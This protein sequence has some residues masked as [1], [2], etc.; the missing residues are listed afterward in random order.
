MQ[1]GIKTGI[2]LAAVVV[3]LP[4]VAGQSLAGFQ[5]GET[6]RVQFTGSNATLNVSLESNVSSVQVYEQTLG[7]GGLNLSVYNSSSNRTKMELHSFDPSAGGGQVAV[8][9]TANTTDGHNVT[10]GFAGLQ[11]DTEYQVKRDNAD[12][13]S[14]TTDSA[15]RKNVSNSAWS[16][17]D[18]V[19][20]NTDTSSDDSDDDTSDDDGDSG[21]SSSGA[22][23]AAAPN[24]RASQ[25]WLASQKSFSLNIER[26]DVEVS[27]VELELENNVSGLSLSVEQ[28][29]GQ[30]NGTAELPN[31]YTF[32]DISTDE[33]SDDNISRV[34]VEV[35]VNRSFAEQFDRVQINRYTG[36]AWEPLPTEP[37][38][39]EGE[40]W[41][42][43]GVSEGN[44]YYGVQGVAEE[45]EEEPATNE[46]QEPACGDGVCGSGETWES[47]AQDCE[48]PQQVIDAENAIERAEANVSE[49][50]AGYQTLQS[51]R[52]AFEAEDY[53]R[54]EQL[55]R[56]ALSA[57]E[58]PEGVGYGVKTVGALLV[59][60]LTLLAV[61]YWFF[62]VRDETP[63]FEE[64][65]LERADYS[66][67]RRYASR[68]NDIRAN[69]SRDNLLEALEE[70]QFGTDT[71]T[72]Q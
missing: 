67:L 60:L 17:R 68:F 26:D 35:S 3:L 8:N 58:E 44:S 4:A 29:P 69:Q 28:L 54:A 45:D 23:A 18:F 47:C 71:G 59:V 10:F 53:A 52:D 33:A 57:G 27:T 13:V 2:I 37:V 22:T 55:A 38:E 11:A 30:P 9:F 34:S 36:D 39:T 6:V 56:D 21:G 66:T 15:G 50:E 64:A 19:V 46:T 5:S 42:Y 14:F 51:A 32:V 63:P 12:Y 20:E 48:K 72:Q 25:T 70:K 41:T 61:I 65:D 1:D 16:A 43:R 7:L 49:G 24:P 40:E 62:Y 31:A